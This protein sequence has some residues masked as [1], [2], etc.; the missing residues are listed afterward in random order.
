MEKFSRYSLDFLINEIL[1]NINNDII[2][3]ELENLLEN[4]KDYIIKLIERKHE[5]I[6]ELIRKRY[7]ND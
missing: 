5:K 6:Q 7:V 1:K 2:I 4:R 3:F